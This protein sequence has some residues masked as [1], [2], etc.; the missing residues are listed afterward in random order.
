MHELDRRYWLMLAL[1]VVLATASIAAPA[2]A[3]EGNATNST[4]VPSTPD[5]SSVVEDDGGNL[6]GERI[7]EST[8]LV[9]ASYDRGSGTATVVL[10]S[11]RPQTV[12][13]TDA[14]GIFEGGDISRRRLVIPQGRSEIT[15]P[16]TESRGFVGVSIATSQTLYG[17]PLERGT[18]VDPPVRS[19]VLA[20]LG[21][22]ASAIAAVWLINARRETLADEGVLRIDG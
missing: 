21:G 13:V 18:S 19:W 17:V 4:D 9:S 6:T 16:V 20:V 8:V 11:S 12:T 15:I 5:P 1:L 2:A 7:D 22:V 14:G 3:Q 10:R